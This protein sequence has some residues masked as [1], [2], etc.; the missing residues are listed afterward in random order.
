MEESKIKSY[1][2]YVDE[3]GD[4]TYS[5]NKRYLALTGVIFES[6]YYKDVFHPYFEKFKQNHFPHNPDEPVILHR[7]EILDKKGAFWRL[8]DKDKHQSFDD[9]F[10]VLL[11]NNKFMIITVVIDKKAHFDRYKESAL[12][13]YHFCLVALLERYCGVLNYY[14]VKGDVLAESRGGREDVVAGPHCVRRRAGRVG[15]RS[16]AVA[17]G[18]G[19]LPFRFGTEPHGIAGAVD[20]GGA[21][22]R[23][24]R[25]VQCGPGDHARD[26]TRARRLD[27]L[28]RVAGI[29]ARGF[30]RVDVEGS[31]NGNHL[32]APAFAGVRAS[33]V[34]SPASIIDP[35]VY[36]P[37]VFSDTGTY[38]RVAREMLRLDGA[39][40]G[41]RPQADLL[42]G[43]ELVPLAEDSDDLLAADAREELGFGAGR[44]DHHHLGVETVVGEVEMLGA[45]AVDDRLT[46]DCGSG[47][48]H[49]QMRAGGHP[50]R[51][52]AIDAM[53]RA[54]EEIHRRRA[55]EP[56]DEAIRGPVVELERVAHLL[57]AAVVHDDDLVGH[58]HGLDLVVGHVHGGGLQPLMRL[59]VVDATPLRAGALLAH[60]PVAR[61]ASLGASKRE[62]AKLRGVSAAA[63]GLAA[64]TRDDS[65]HDYSA[66]HRS[67]LLV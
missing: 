37:I 31:P 62:V 58:G 27:A 18:A 64:R 16:G 42:P 33:V 21:N 4:H 6:Q 41:A 55:D 2:M 39:H 23:R 44:L 53:D 5:E 60:R 3:S 28:G 59:A 10:I 61:L 67:V 30:I 48:R 20:D 49:G 43:R 63:A 1:R 12:H 38:E 9:D 17:I 50:Y 22:R 66:G 8:Q 13:P 65:G 15:P 56:G 46:F 14:N 25:L 54:L 29:G 57:D 35:L 24:L 51:A 11:E 52:P 19:G 45:N 7:R 36:E 34:T 40:L 26:R 32:I 47:G